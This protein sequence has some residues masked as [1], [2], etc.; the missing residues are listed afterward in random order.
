ML[1]GN[2]TTRPSSEALACRIGCASVPVKLD[3]IAAFEV[4]F[5][6]KRAGSIKGLGTDLDKIPAAWQ[7]RATSVRCEM[8]QRVRSPP[9]GKKYLYFHP[10]LG[11]DP[12]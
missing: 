3:R 10:Y 2:R 12:M 5:Q 9:G 6:Q 8:T 1:F 11:H 7:A 4:W